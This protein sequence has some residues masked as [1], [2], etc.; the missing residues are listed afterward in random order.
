MQRQIQPKL[1]V[2]TIF[3]VLFQGFLFLCGANRHIVGH[4]RTRINGIK[5]RADQGD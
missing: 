3:P 5:T 2:F 4:A 1:R